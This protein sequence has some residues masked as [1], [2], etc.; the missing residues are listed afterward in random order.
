MR[1]TLAGFAKLAWSLYKG[2]LSDQGMLD[3]AQDLKCHP[4]NKAPADKM[5]DTQ[6]GNRI[7]RHAVMQANATACRG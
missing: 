7:H 5:R 2:A 6:Q 3:D 1:E 4:S